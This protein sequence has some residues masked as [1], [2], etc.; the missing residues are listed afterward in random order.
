M[1]SAKIGKQRKQVAAQYKY[2]TNRFQNK[3]VDSLQKEVQ[4]VYRRTKW[5][6]VTLYAKQHSTH[7]IYSLIF[8]VDVNS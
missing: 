7:F 8:D 6:Y 3:N 5:A 1:L 2:R 4:I